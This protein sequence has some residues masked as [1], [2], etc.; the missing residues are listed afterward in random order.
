MGER[1]YRRGG[2]LRFVT[3]RIGACIVLALSAVIAV[4]SP[5]AAAAP[6]APTIRSVLAGPDVGTMSLR[7]TA[8]VVNGGFA[9]TSYDYRVQ[10]DGGAFSL[11]AS[12]GVGSANTATVPCLAPAG[13]GHG[14]GYEVRAENGTAGAWSV[15]VAALWTPPS[16]ALLGSAV[17]GPNLGQATLTWRPP[18]QTGGLAVQY[19][20]EVN[21]GSGYSAPTNIPAAS[22]TPVTGQ[23]FPL[24]SAVVNCPIV[25]PPANA[26]SYVLQAFNAAGAGPLSKA[27]TTVLTRPSKPTNLQI[28]TSTV[29]LGTGMANQS[30]TWTPAAANGGLPVNDEVVW[31]CAT[32]DGSACND[33]APGWTLVSDTAGNTATNATHSC[34]PNGR[35][36]YE[37]WARNAI[38]RGWT[39][40]KSLPG[41]PT[42]LSATASIAAPGQIDLQWLNAVQVGSGFGHY[43]LFECDAS[44][45]CTNG[46]WDNVAAHAAPWTRVDLTGTA[47]T[48]SYDCSVFVTCTFRVGYMD[49]AGNIGG[50]SNSVTAAGLDAPKLTV[51]PGTGPGQINLSW[52]APSSSSPISN[53]QI[54]RDTGSGFVHYQTVP[55]LPTS[56]VDTGCTPGTTCTYKIRAFYDVGQSPDSN[57]GSAVSPLDTPVTI[58]T[59]TANARVP[60]STPTLA[61]AAAGATGDAATVTVKIYAGATTA[62]ALQQTLSA[63]RVGATWTINANTLADGTYTA[64]ASELNYAGTTL[65]STPVTFAVDTTSPVVT[66]TTANGATRTFPFNSNATI[67]TVG[68]ACGSAAGD[69]ATVTVAV[70][71]GITEGGTAPCT[72]GAWN[73]T[74]TSPFVNGNTY[75]VTATQA[76]SAGNTG[77]SGAATISVDTVIPVVTLT[78]VNGTVRTFPYR[79]NATVTTLGGACGTLTGDSATVSITITGASTQNGTAAC[80]SGA[81]T[82]TPTVAFSTDGT[83]T[84][85][86]TQTDSAL[87]TGTSGAQQVIVDK[88][89]PIVTVTAVNG[90]ARTFPYLTNATV[91]SVGGTC[92]ALAGDGTTVLISETGAGS[93]N[94]AATCVAGAW[95]YSFISAL[96]VNGAYTITATQTDGG[97]NT[98]TSGG[99]TITVDRTAPLVTLTTVNGSVRTFPYSTNANL[100]TVGGA[101]GATAG[102]A[103]T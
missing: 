75:S 67:T 95:S 28:F 78:T 85:T 31:A 7:W 23:P 97:G 58:T 65:L 74:L 34:K 70:T 52:I 89:A 73:F 24:L 100:T 68:G 9:I 49:A 17:A 37:V 40:N 56:Y 66:L 102:D 32:A 88:T 21:T 27:R 43:V 61:G 25:T 77:T 4:A 29:A 14:C 92:G 39:I 6:S 96:T 19:R 26:C 93:E 38:G 1:E 10:I 90:T 51:T 12:L 33:A 22:I 63:P 30:V 48:T 16:V 3:L 44:Q 87:N 72:A 46:T 15:P 11:P 64:Q 55:A 69:I 54:D 50:V 81:W 98:G 59:P 60:S 53:Y 94:G 36:G 99:Q 103:A 13:A 84:V 18:T 42:T 35:C 83:Y 47:T 20:Y 62:G 82:F 5:A 80:T 57:T 76:D 86:V 41:V 45:V 91:T 8:P 71:G 2:S 79:T 101:C